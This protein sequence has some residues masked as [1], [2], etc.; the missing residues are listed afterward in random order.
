MLSV[1]KW[2]PAGFG[3]LLNPPSPFLRLQIRAKEDFNRDQLF[4][5]NE[6]YVKISPYLT[7]AFLNRQSWVEGVIFPF[8]YLPLFHKTSRLEDNN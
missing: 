3:M 7:W 8:H 6:Q 4:S 1:A 2:W 5:I